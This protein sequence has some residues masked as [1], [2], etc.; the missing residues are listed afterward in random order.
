MSNPDGVNELYAA[1]V[2]E[3]TA[4]YA[5]V[6]HAAHVDAVVIGAGTPHPVFLDDQ[7]LPFKPNPYLLHWGP[8]TEHPGS[9]LVVRL[10]ADPEWLIHTPVDYW[11]KVPQPPDLLAEGPVRIT[12]VNSADDIAN[13]VQQLPKRRAFIGEAVKPEDRFGIANTNP[14]A[15]IAAINELRTR[16]SPWE[17]DNMRRATA[18]GVRGHLAAERC[19]LAGGS[20]YDIHLA[21]RSAC[22][23]TDAEMP[24]PAIVALN[25]HAATLHYQRLERTVSAHHSLLI[26]AGAAWQ[27]YA[28][29]ITR[30]HSEDAE[31]GAL[32]EAMHELQRALCEAALPGVDYRELHHAAH[33]GIAGLLRDAELISVA[34]ETAAEAGIVRFFFPHGLGHFLGLQVHDVGALYTRGSATDTA[35]SNGADKHLR[36][37]RTL[38][39]GNVLTVEPG[40]YF[41]PSLLDELQSSPHTGCINWPRIDGLRPFGGIRIEDNIHITDQGNEN[42]TR[43]A[44]AAAAE[45]EADSG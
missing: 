19:F 42:L 44:F 3:L 38:Q 1:H 41:I 25:A 23:T 12:V 27:G 9:A 34:P 24:Y 8:L 18:R 5:E 40:L 20:E 17:V 29:D 2:S 28:S 11:H 22:R 6:L 13:R 45:S 43:A 26:D 30:T 35:A 36:L 10:D 37:T 15:L 39:P 14:A 21:F 16:K 4:H 31:F 32:I 33:L 7:H